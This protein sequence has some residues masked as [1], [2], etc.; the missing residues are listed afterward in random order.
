[1]ALD[2]INCP[3]SFS[4]IAFSTD[5]RSFVSLMQSAALRAPSNKP[6]PIESE[7]N[8]R[9]GNCETVRQ[10]LP[11]CCASE[12]TSQLPL[13]HRQLRSGVPRSCLTRLP[14]VPED[15]V[16]S[17]PF[18]PKSHPRRLQMTSLRHSLVPASNGKLRCPRTFRSEF[19]SWRWRERTAPH[20][21]QSH[22]QVLGR[23][24]AGVHYRDRTRYRYVLPSAVSGRNLLG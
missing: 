6:K 19:A 20:R 13:L 14:H 2:G 16:R 18:L 5:L 12:R 9:K 10:P 1:M 7:L 15:P 21:Q 4:A 23:P 22:R 8:T 3:D 11:P 24:T 17:Y